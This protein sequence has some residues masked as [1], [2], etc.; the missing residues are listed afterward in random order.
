VRASRQPTAVSIREPEP[1][2]TQLAPEQ[3]VLLY[4]VAEGIPLA[5]LKPPG[6]HAEHYSEGGNV[7]H[8]AGA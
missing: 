6:Q 5:A 7:N 1:T 3:S 4:E 8:K 2:A